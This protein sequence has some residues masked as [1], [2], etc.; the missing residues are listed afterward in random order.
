MYGQGHREPDT[1]RTQAEGSGGEEGGG[2]TPSLTVHLI[3]MP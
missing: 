3:P 2:S 1:K